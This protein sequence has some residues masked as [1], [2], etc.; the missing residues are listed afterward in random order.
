MTFYVD[1]HQ[2]ENF[3]AR[4]L[5]FP[6]YVFF[7]LPNKFVAVFGDNAGVEYDFLHH[8]NHKINL[9]YRWIVGDW[10]ICSATCARGKFPALLIRSN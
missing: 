8:V 9:Q 2:Y 5:F 7:L 1:Y 3:Q 4:M 10:S 6:F